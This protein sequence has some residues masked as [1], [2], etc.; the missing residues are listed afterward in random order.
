MS[1]IRNKAA[2]S[3]DGLEKRRLLVPGLPEVLALLFNI[4]CYA[5]HYPEYWRENR[6]TLIPKPNE[7]LNRPKT[8]GP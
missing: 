3:P 2:A 4:L 6:I 7:D 8:G 5:S 1:K